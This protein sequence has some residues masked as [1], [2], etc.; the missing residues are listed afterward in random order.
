MHSLVTNAVHHVTPRE[1]TNGHTN[2]KSQTIHFLIIETFINIV[3][4]LKKKEVGL[5]VP[6]GG[7]IRMIFLTTNGISLK[8]S[9][10]QNKVSIRDVP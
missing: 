5:R 3:A 7:V 9:G 4:A 6:K 2:D 8:S 1:W 10:Q